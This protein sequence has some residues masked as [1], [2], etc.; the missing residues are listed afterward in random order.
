MDKKQALNGL[1]FE[2]GA[3]L[4][5]SQ[6]LEYDLKYLIYLTS[7]LR[8][9]DITLEQANSIIE[10]KSKQTL[11]Q[12]F[13]ILKDKGI[14]DLFENEVEEILADAIQARNVLI[15]GFLVG[16]SEKILKYDT[17]QALTLEVRA[18]R[19]RIKGGSET[20][21]P[22]LEILT[23]ALTGLSVDTTKEGL[24]NE[25]GIKHWL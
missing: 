19:R 23:E 16:N 5:D 14:K 13:R 22:I 17:R 4:Y 25:F 7:R 12:L 2:A 3:G 21:K 15:H 18:L 8:F 10:G 20:I 24:A 9:W 6:V 11:G 1:Y